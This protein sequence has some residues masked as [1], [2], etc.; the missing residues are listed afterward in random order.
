MWE[1]QSIYYKTVFANALLVYLMDLNSNEA[2][3]LPMGYQ[4]EI[5]QQEKQRVLDKSKVL[6]FAS[7]LH[8]HDTNKSSLTKE[9]GLT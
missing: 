9:W 1:V 5:T 3:Y 7:R 2:K 8:I 4:G 6:C